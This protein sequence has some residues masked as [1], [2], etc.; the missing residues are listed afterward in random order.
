[1]I[2]DA[3]IE[4]FFGRLRE[5][6]L[7]ALGVIYDRYC[8]LVYAI[9]YRVLKNPEEAEEVV[10]EV[11][12]AVYRNSAAKLAGKGSVKAWIIGITYN[13]SVTRWRKLF[14]QRYYATESFETSYVW[15]T[16]VLPAYDD[17]LPLRRR[18]K[19][20]VAALPP[21]QRQTL[22]MY[23]WEGYELSEIADHLQESFSNT[24]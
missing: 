9:A 21:R 17:F 18:L 22:T 14:S 15:K 10:Q 23:F 3:T 6:D 24:R 13:R 1:P 12:L 8:R 16:P 4:Y 5:G 7:S 11:F 19:D 20:A 2:D